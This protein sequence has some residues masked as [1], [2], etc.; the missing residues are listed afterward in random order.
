MKY[1]FLAIFII[2]STIHLYASYKS[3]SKLR[4]QTK[5]FILLSLLGWYCLNVSDP[6]VIIIA[7]IL[8]SWLGDVLLIP[9]GVKWFSAGGISFFASH[10]CFAVAYAYHINFALVPP[11]VII[12]GAAV[13]IALTALVF[14]GLTP[15]LPK[16]LVF[17]MA[18]Y[19]LANGAMN[20]FALYQLVSMPCLATAITFI[21]AILFFVSDSTLFYVRFKKDCLFKTH[22]I[23]MLTYIL[24]EFLIVEGFVLMAAM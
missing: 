12:A 16:A 14:R 2:T 15:Y 9:K 3:N 6:L 18:G 24:S 4:A 1:L 19:L 21:G 20:C 13:Y 11:W 22:F 8:T 17:P 23:V 10:V 7:A 5:G